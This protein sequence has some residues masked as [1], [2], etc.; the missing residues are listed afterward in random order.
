MK[1]HNLFFTSIITILLIITG[2]TAKT[3]LI[4]A[5]E[6]GDSLAVQK[7]ISEGA[8]VNG[9]DS[10]GYTPLMSA[11]WAGKI[12]T[13]KVLLHKGANINAQD[14][15]GSTSLMHAV[16]ERQVEVSKYLIKSGADTNVKNKEGE[17]VL[18][19][20]L[21][22]S[23]WDVVGDLIRA[24]ANLWLPEA[25]K[26]RIVFISRDLYDYIK[27]TVGNKSKSINE[28]RGEVGMA[29]FDVDPGRHIIDANY[30]KY[31]SKDRAS[32]DLI[33][34]QTYYFKVTQNMKD[35]ILGYALFSPTLVGKIS[36][37]SPFPIIP[38]T[39]SE[40]KHQIGVLLKSSELTEPQKSNPSVSTEITKPNR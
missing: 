8:N 24:G 23:Q 16:L 37:N 38:M 35:R 28:D 26:A 33:A 14:N 9:T 5:S 31:V 40:A 19:I 12:E 36:G 11:V 20:A 18:D 21:S 25:E 29:I 6:A 15:Y 1:H 30:D 2:C 39:E 32:I 4:R 10:E 3:P 7:L 17:T 22:F 27:V 34:G 13:V